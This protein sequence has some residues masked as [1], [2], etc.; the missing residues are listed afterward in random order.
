MKALLDYYAT[1]EADKDFPEASKFY[2][3]ATVN[4]E[5][6][7]ESISTSSFDDQMETDNSSMSGDDSK[8]NASPDFLPSD[9]ENIDNLSWDTIS[10]LDNISDEEL[11][12]I[13]SSTDLV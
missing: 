8:L 12:S 2:N 4:I 11:I 9:I 5:D 3:I 1:Y 10:L 7:M 6:K 13:L